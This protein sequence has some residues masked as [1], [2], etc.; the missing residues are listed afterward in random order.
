MV[1]NAPFVA[2]HVMVLEPTLD[3]LLPSSNRLSKYEHVIVRCSVTE[4]YLLKA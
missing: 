3:T 2:H 4:S 1:V